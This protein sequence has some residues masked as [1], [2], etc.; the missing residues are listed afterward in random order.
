MA[1]P[2]LAHIHSSVGA[3][4][5]W[6]FQLSLEAAGGAGPATVFLALVP[7]SLSTSWFSMGEKKHRAGSSDIKIKMYILTHFEYSRVL[8]LVC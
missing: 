6:G 2:S 5:L 8:C 7:A 1:S 3:E 4:E